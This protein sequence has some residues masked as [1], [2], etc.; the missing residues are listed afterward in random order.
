MLS[1]KTTAPSPEDCV[2]VIALARL[3]VD[4]DGIRIAGSPLLGGWDNF[5]D[6]INS[7]EGLALDDPE[8]I[9][10]EASYEQDGDNHNG[11]ITVADLFAAR[12]DDGR[13]AFSDEHGGESFVEI[14]R[15]IRVDLGAELGVR[16][17]AIEAADNTTAPRM[18][19]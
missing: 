8:L 1:T 7:P 11:C 4:A 18:R 13:L 9:A 2:R 12:L 19:S 10:F 14:F 17:V 6:S 15:V 5:D 16:D 3:L